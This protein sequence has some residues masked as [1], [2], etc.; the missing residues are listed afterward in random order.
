MNQ[1][2]DSTS[3]SAVDTM[4][5]A[6]DRFAAEHAAIADITALLAADRC[7]TIRASKVRDIL[8]SKGLMT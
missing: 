2:L 1:P 8:R 6:A 3:G 4:L 7:D 5:A